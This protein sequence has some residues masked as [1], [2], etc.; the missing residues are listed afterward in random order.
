MTR[1]KTPQ[2]TFAMTLS[3]E[4]TDLNFIVLVFHPQLTQHDQMLEHAPETRKQEFMS[5]GVYEKTDTKTNKKALSR[6]NR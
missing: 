2:K 5:R 6:V 3:T 4:Q 1:E